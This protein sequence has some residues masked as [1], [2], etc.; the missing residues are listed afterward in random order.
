M[1]KIGSNKAI[2]VGTTGSATLLIVWVA[3]LFGITIPAEVAVAALTVAG[4]L[5]AWLVPTGRA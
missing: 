1:N 4:S 3:G 2:A 5:F